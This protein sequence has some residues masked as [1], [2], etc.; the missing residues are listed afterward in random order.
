M[1]FH[2]RIFARAFTLIELLIVVAIIAILAAIAVPNFLEAQTRAKVSRSVSDLRTIDVALTAYLV[3]NNREPPALFPNASTTVFSEWWGFTPPALTT[4]LSYIS[5]LPSMVFLDEYVSGFWYP[6]LS[7]SPGNQPYTYVRD[8]TVVE[9]WGTNVSTGEFI[10]NSTIG[11]PTGV[12]AENQ[13]PIPEYIHNLARSHGFILYT[14]G[15]D[16]VDATVWGFPQMYDP[17]NGTISNGD[18]YRFGT[19]SPHEAESFM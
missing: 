10:P 6:Q 16:G 12:P 7:A 18:I 8:I 5:S 17:T 9:D 1:R 3:D 14:S 13:G 19:G 4:P 15:P 11:N 2:F